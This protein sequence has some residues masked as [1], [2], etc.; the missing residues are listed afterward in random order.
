[1][2]VFH[3]A[4]FDN[5]ESLHHICDANSGL[6]AIIAIHSTVLGPAAGG[7]RFWHYV[8]PDDALTDVLRLS[9]GM[10]FKNAVAG[11]PFGGGKA[12]I[13]KN[14]QKSR[15]LF[16]AFGRAVDALGGRY[17]TA[18]DVGISV[19]DMQQV[20]E[21]TR[22]V[23]GVSKTSNTV[24]GDPSP[25]TALGVFLGIQAA[26]EFKLGTD[27]MR[28]LHV[29]VQGVGHVGYELCKLLHRAGARLTVADVN[30]DN[31]ARAA[32]EFGAR[33]V[34]PGE[35]LG[36]ECDVLAPCALG[37][38]INDQTLPI[39]K[40]DVIAG[41]ANNQLARD[42]HGSALLERGIVY[43]PDYVINAGGIIAVSR[44]Y[45]GGVNEQSVREEVG[46]IKNRLEQIFQRSVANQEATNLIAD[47]LARSLIE[48]RR[49][50]VDQQIA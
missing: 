7:C 13:L 42:V 21:V 10:T 28:D 8:N 41:A 20:R 9:R 6:N 49:S 43:A 34:A 32:A 19:N 35:I 22:Y 38:I 14:T 33:I 4:D 40:A 29:A 1:M 44:E 11:L 48:P 17:I 30:N 31:T 26:V 50:L 47:K 36:T 3:H 16:R 23:T 39:L 37:S 18:E 25:W 15:E 2:S 46:Q 27:R 5:H 24:G 45:L 12:V